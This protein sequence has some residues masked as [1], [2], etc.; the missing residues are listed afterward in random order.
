MTGMEA[1][2]IDRDIFNRIKELVEVD[3]EGNDTRVQT[4]K[5]GAVTYW[6]DQNKKARADAN[7]HLRKSMLGDIDRFRTITE[8]MSQLN[9]SYNSNAYIRRSLSSEIARIELLDQR[10][11]TEAYKK[12]NDMLQHD[13][14]V[15][16]GSFVMRALLLTFMCTALM[17]LGIGV[18]KEGGF[19]PEWILAILAVVV[20]IV[21]TLTLL[22]MFSA[23][24]KRR[25]THWNHYY[26]NN[27]EQDGGVGCPKDKP[28]L[29][30]PNDDD[31]AYEYD[32]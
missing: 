18:W 15:Q 24:S 7:T 2:Q 11:Q 3:D 14:A 17:S 12:Q 19:L 27:P 32:D 29:N 6:R 20:L 31:D 16:Y 9:E 30:P 4:I 10:A 21:Y 26:F 28:R 5:K 8:L 22:L 25:K 1:E 13:H 23:T